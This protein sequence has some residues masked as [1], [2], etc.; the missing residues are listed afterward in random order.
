MRPSRPGM[1]SYRHLLACADTC[2][3][4]ATAEL[5]QAI[6]VEHAC[7]ARARSFGRP[8]DGRFGALPVEDKTPPATISATPN[9]A[10]SGNASPQIS[11]PMISAQT[12][13][14]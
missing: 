13:M 14:L 9:T 3:I 11:W 10:R 4:P 12:T 6:V 8:Q 7:S 5:T 1:H 2:Q